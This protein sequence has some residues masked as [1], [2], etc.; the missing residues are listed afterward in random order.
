MKPIQP[1]D[2]SRSKA[3]VLQRCLKRIKEEYKADPSFES[4]THLDAMTLNLE[5]ACQAA[6]DLANHTVSKSKL[7]VP[8]SS[9]EAFKLLA[10]SGIID[11]PMAQELAAM[12]GFR[13]IAVHQY[14]RIQNEVLKAIVENK[15]EIFENLCRKL[16]IDIYSPE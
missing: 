5:R 4:F 16:G 8:N 10:D 13:N 15:L 9:A 3:A 6:I 7:G 1:D 12:S 14:Q 2:V 11:K